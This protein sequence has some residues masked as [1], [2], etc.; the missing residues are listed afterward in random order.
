[1]PLAPKMVA[2]RST[3]WLDMPPEPIM[4]ISQ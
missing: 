2:A 4:R 3:S 1:M